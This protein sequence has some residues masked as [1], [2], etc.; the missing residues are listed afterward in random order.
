MMVSSTY[1][2]S[3]PTSSDGEAE[4]SQI[5]AGIVGFA[6]DEGA[7]GEHAQGVVGVAIVHATL[8]GATDGKDGLAEVVVDEVACL[9][10]DADV[11]GV[12]DDGWRY[13]LV[14]I[15]KALGA[16]LAAIDEGDVAQHDHLAC[17]GTGN[18]GCFGKDI[19]PPAF[20]HPTLH[21]QLGMEVIVGEVACLKAKYHGDGCEEHQSLA[22]EEPF[23]RQLTEEGEEDGDDED[24]IEGKLERIVAQG[25][26]LELV[27]A[28]HPRLVG[29]NEGS[30]GC[31]QQ[32]HE[33]NGEAQKEQG[34]WQGLE[35]ADGASC[36]DGGC[37][38]GI[39][40]EGIVEERCRE[41]YPDEGD[42]A[43]DAV[44]D[45]QELPEG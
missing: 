25:V 7:L 17:D 43:P 6:V 26:E 24:E 11:N 21:A 15:C 37:Q 39:D 18:A 32:G 23:R 12:A 5:L 42:G 20:L 28:A 13:A 8:D 3:V 9:V 38:E 10:A 27:E 36:H 14:I 41:R 1:L 35:A 29:A 44:P 30:A 2:S 22:V 31:L 4:Q 45:W 33:P 40:A 19:V 34:E 16:Q